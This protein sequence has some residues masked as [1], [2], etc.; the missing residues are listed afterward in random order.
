V[1]VGATHAR[2]G[3]PGPLDALAAADQ[4]LYEAKAA[5]RDRVAVRIL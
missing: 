1:S 5:G 2:G 4:A 3:H